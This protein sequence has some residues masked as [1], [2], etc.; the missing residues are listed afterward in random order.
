VEDLTKG[1]GGVVKVV[2]KVA[3]EDKNRY[4]DLKDD[5]SPPDQHPGDQAQITARYAVCVV[6]LGA[7]TGASGGGGGGDDSDDSAGTQVFPD[8]GGMAALSY[9]VDSG[10]F[11]E[12][13]DTCVKS[14]RA[15]EEASFTLRPR[16]AFG[17]AGCE[18]HGVPPGASV[19]DPRCLGERAAVAVCCFLA[20]TAIAVGGWLVFQSIDWLGR[21]A[22]A[23][24][25]ETRGRT[26]GRDKGAR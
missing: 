3:P 9:V 21:M 7:D 16:F 26:A 19:S 8:G 24:A 14:M 22:F 15:G 11:P 25:R 23:L 12:G 2:T 17:D 20:A 18:K 1:E 5:E 10:E 13:F 4:A 6:G